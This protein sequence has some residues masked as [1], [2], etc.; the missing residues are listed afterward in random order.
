MEELKKLKKLFDTNKTG[1]TNCFS[2][3]CWTDGL[4]SIE[5]VDDWHKWIEKEIPTLKYKYTTPEIAIEQFFEHIKKNNIN[6]K[7]LQTDD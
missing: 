6:I 1:D 2:L 7:E 3:V 5:V 4:W